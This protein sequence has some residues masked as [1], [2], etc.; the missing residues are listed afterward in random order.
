M[1]HHALKSLLR[2]HLIVHHVHHK[3]DKIKP[4]GAFDLP[5]QNIVLVM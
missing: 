4:G 3:D 1:R 5:T 2:S